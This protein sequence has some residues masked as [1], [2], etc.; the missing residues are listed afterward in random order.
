MFVDTS[1]LTEHYNTLHLPFNIYFPEL[2]LTEVTHTKAKKLTY[3][4]L[5][6]GTATQSQLKVGGG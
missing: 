6:K 3:L 4:Q 2:F 5:R 1:H